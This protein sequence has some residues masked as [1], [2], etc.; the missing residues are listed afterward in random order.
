MACSPARNGI[1][2]SQLSKA[3]SRE[4]REIERRRLVLDDFCDK[5]RCDGC[6][7][8]AVVAMAERIDYASILAGRPDHRQRVRNGGAKAHPAL[9]GL[10]FVE[11]RQEAL[12][13]RDHRRGA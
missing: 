6:L 11:M 7:R 13:A 4:R 5:A 1:R 9:R 2:L 3:L 8:Q 10:A 12:E